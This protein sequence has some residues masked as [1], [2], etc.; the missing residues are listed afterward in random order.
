MRK[1][2]GAVVHGLTLP[3][4]T[5]STGEKMGKSAGNALWLD[6][7]LTSPFIFFQHFLNTADADT[8]KFLR[9]LTLLPDGD[10]PLPPFPHLAT[11]RPVLPP[12]PDLPSDAIAAVAERH[13]SAPHERAAQRLLAE[14]VFVSAPSRST[15]RSP[16]W[17]TETAG[18]R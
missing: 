4:L 3:L 1:R 5:T 11:P 13:R 14:Q 8:E 7:A 17:C 2:C 9:L 15:P 12:R 6:P 16:D 10:Y 18:W